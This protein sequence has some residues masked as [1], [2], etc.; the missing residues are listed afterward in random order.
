[1]GED[2]I[3]FESHH[4]ALSPPRP[5]SLCMWMCPQELY[6]AEVQNTAQGQ[7]AQVQAWPFYFLLYIS[8]GRAASCCKWPYLYSGAETN[9]MHLTG[10]AK[11]WGQLLTQSK[12]CP[13]VA[14][15][16]IWVWCSEDSPAVTSTRG[17]LLEV[18]CRNEV[19]PGT[20][21][22]RTLDHLVPVCY[23]AEVYVCLSVFIWPLAFTFSRLPTIR[24][25]AW[26]YTH[27]QE[28][29]GNTARGGIV[30]AWWACFYLK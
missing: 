19:V 16:V 26:V 24:Q 5:F 17:L 13:S 15:D 27:S 12:P 28:S 22:D 1:M 4:F 29:L 20:G 21:A 25:E 6:S 30:V 11:S 9:N 8:L 3:P 2:N 18:C 7:A 10:C 14:A 23:C